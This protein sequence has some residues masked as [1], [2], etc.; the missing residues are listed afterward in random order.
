M[1]TATLGGLIKDYR[2]KKRL[3]Q[4]EVSMR[5]G[6]KDTTRLSKIEQGRVG[7]PTRETVD[8]IIKA[9]DLNGQEKGEFLLIGGYLPT[10]EE[11]IKMVRQFKVRINNWPYPAY[12]I[13]FSWRSLFLN[14]ATG[15]DL[16]IPSEILRQ[17]IKNKYNLLEFVGAPKVVLAS[18]L[19]KGDDEYNLQHFDVAQIAQFKVEQ[20]GRE[21]DSWYKKLIAKLSKNEYFRKQ[22]IQ[23]KPQSYH[24]KLLD[25]EYKEVRWP[26]KIFKYHVF[27]S[28]LIED[29]RFQL[30]LYLPV[31]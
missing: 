24:K 8:K 23:V 28:R 7:K 16:G 2:I 22:W 17:A 3:S 5:I 18:E 21:K 20:I 1:L 13:D 19:Y 14:E 27:T 6:W 26:D 12:M 10:D 11:I 9:L 25:Y 30:V 31:K 15:K 4:L 29:Q